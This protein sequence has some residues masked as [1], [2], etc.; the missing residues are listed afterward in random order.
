M[1]WATWTTSA[2]PV[3]PGGVR[4]EE[5]GIL[6]GDV[7]V[8]T[9]WRSGQVRIRVRPTG[10][11]QWLT[12]SGVLAFC[13]T[14]YRSRLLHEATVEAVRADAEESPLPTRAAA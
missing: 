13:P 10:T 14:A 11:A 1:S 3:G 8:Q 7:D 5:A 2:V 4:T 12:L 6:T 9:H